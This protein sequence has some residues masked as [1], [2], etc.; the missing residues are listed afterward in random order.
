MCGETRILRDMCA[1]KHS[2]LGNTYHWNTGV[3]DP[4]NSQRASHKRVGYVR[5]D[6]KF[7]EYEAH[8]DRLDS[9]ELIIK[10]NIHL[11]ITATSEGTR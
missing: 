2:S 7:S 5:L 1:G 10:Y 11:L 4:E 9:D 8:T 3:C 6:C